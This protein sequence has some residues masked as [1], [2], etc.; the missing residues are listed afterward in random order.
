MNVCVYVVMYKCSKCVCECMCLYVCE[1]VCV[2]AC[3]YVY[4]L[5]FNSPIVLD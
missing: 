2:Y 3:A 5:L 1:R 4:G